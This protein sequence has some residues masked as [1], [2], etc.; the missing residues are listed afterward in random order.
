M[1]DQQFPV[2][3]DLQMWE[4]IFQRRNLLLGGVLI[5]AQERGKKAF[6]NIVYSV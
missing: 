3:L 4:I 1:D 2:S 6:E 5:A